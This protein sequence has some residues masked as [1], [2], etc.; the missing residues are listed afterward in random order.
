MKLDSP[1][2]MSV[3]RIS[4]LTRIGLSPG[5]FEPSDDDEGDCKLVFIS[6]ALRPEPTS[7]QVTIVFIDAH[8]M[9][10]IWYMCKM[11]FLFIEFLFKLYVKSSPVEQPIANVGSLK[12]KQLLLA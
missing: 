5:L 11:N 7:D 8:S 9:P 3:N 12:L 10:F 1:D 4:V 6:I 2:R